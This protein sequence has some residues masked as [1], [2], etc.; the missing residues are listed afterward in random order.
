M[1]WFLYDNGLHHER[2]KQ[3]LEGLILLEIYFL[4]RNFCESIFRMDRN[5]RNFSSFKWINFHEKV[6]CGRIFTKKKYKKFY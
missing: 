1:D 2:V 5:S 6:P 4:R 3:I